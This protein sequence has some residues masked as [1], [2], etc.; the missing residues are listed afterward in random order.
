VRTSPRASQRVEQDETRPDER[1]L[2]LLEL[3]VAIAL[4]S[5]MMIG[6]AA[7]VSSGLNLSR[8]D[9]NR[10]VAANLAAQEMDT[11]RESNFTTLVSR[12]T[13]Q[14]VDNVPFSVRRDLT[15]VSKSATSGPCDASGGTPQVLRV[16]VTVTWPDMHGVNPVQTDTVMSPPVGSYDPNT[17]HIAVKVLDRDANPQDNAVVNLS[18]PKTASLPTNE[19]GCAFFTFLTPG[20]YTVTLATTGDVDRQSNPNPAQVVGVNLGQISAVQ[21]DYD[22]AASLNLTLQPS[23]GG[24]LPTDLPLTIANSH[25]LGNGTQPY[26]GTGTSRTIGNLFPAEEGYTVWPG[27][28]ADADPQGQQIVGG[29][30]AGAYWPNAVR[31]PAVATTPGATTVGTVTV[32]TVTLTVKDGTGTAVPGVSLTATHAAD[33]ICTAGETHVLGT[34]DANGQLVVGVPYGHWTV[35][36]A[37]RTAQGG[38]WPQ[39]VVDPNASS[40]TTLEV[41]VA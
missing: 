21:F 37:G 17:G 41:D 2:T 24:V 15:W 5:I 32:P 22:Q 29:V 18:G 36:V 7:T 9:R 14:N 13:T 38:T 25:F 6:I 1:G 30:A 34:T 16:E 39:L 11:V 26:S 40:P 12:T 10:S 3:V 28:C 31:A 19:Q 20:T 33:N 8:T 23:S 35:S 4:L 27:Q